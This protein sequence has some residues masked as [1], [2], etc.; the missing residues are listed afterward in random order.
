MVNRVPL[1][2]ANQTLKRRFDP[3]GAIKPVASFTQATRTPLRAVDRLVTRESIDRDLEHAITD[4]ALGSRSVQRFE[5][6]TIHD[7]TVFLIPG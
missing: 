2:L 1:R 6:L 3:N 4:S 7:F 5:A